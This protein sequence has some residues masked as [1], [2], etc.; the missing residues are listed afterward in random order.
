MLILG[1]AVLLIGTMPQYASG[2]AQQGS[3]PS[4]VLKGTY[5]NYT[6]SANWNGKI[7]LSNS[8]SM[9]IAGNFTGSVKFYVN[10][11]TSVA[12]SQLANVTEIP[13]FVLK[14]MLTYFNGT[15]QT[16]DETA[17]PAANS[18]SSLVP[19]ASLNFG[20]LLQEEL[21]STTSLYSFSPTLNTS[22]STAPGVLYQLN[23]TTQVPALH[24]TSSISEKNTLPS[25]LTV[26]GN[27]S[28]NGTSDI[29]VAMV[30]DI[31]LKEAISMQGSGNAQNLNL[32]LTTQSATGSASFSATLSLAST[33]VDLSAGK[34]VEQASI[35]IPNFS[36]SLD[37]ISNS[38]I[39]GAGTSGNHLVVNVTG[40]SGTTGVLDVVVSPSLLTS[41]GLSNPSQ[42]GVTLNG[43]TY[44]NYTITDL[45]GSYLFTIYYHHSS[46]SIAMS[47]GNANLGTNTGQIEG[48]GSQGSS[49]P[50]SLTTIL[51]I[52][53]V[54]IVVVAVAIIAVRRK[55]PGANV[56][57]AAPS[58][59]S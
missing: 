30:Q 22:L 35:K 59:A 47:F 29:Y 45:G 49:L 19:L 53:V 10:N 32:G 34:N 15:T 28:L 9:S 40:T 50:I 38:T 42:V 7:S 13:N 12:G 23:S 41:A 57:A 24:L 27:Y 8:S 55:R 5:L 36:T 21:N 33:N 3:N 25:S 2:Q 44:T 16:N 39:E 18:S 54:V 37:V 43:T 17:T 14:D 46:H 6:G 26:T 20:N 31:P 1:F 11:L 4:W 48:L 58:P 52:V 56:E 51:E